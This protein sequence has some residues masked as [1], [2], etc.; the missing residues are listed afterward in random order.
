MQYGKIISNIA[1][2]TEHL[3]SPVNAADSLQGWIKIVYVK[4]AVCQMPTSLIA[5]VWKYAVNVGGD[6]KKEWGAK[7]LLFKEL[8]ASLAIGS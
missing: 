6:C 1:F 3:P 7:A 4:K 2:S 5:E 8:N